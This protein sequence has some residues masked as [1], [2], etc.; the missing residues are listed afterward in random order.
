MGSP[1]RL[2]TSL[3]NSEKD[4]VL[5]RRYR[6]VGG[7]WQNSN[8]AGPSVADHCRDGGK[9]SKAGTTPYGVREELPCQP[10][11][12]P[13]PPPQTEQ[14]PGS[15]ALTPLK[16]KPVGDRQ[17]ADD[18]RSSVSTAATTE[19]S[20]GT[21]AIVIPWQPRRAQPLKAE[22]GMVRRFDDAV[23]ANEAG[24]GR[25]A[26]EKK[27]KKKRRGKP[28]PKE[29]N[30]G[31]DSDWEWNDAQVGHTDGGM[32]D[33]AE[34]TCPVRGC[35]ETILTLNLDSH[36]LARH[37]GSS[38]AADIR[39][40][41]ENERAFRERKE[42]PAEERPRIAG[43]RCPT[44]LVGILLA[45]GS[46]S[47]VSANYRPHPE[48]EKALA[49][50]G[51]EQR[52]Q[53]QQ[54]W[55]LARICARLVCSCRIERIGKMRERSLVELLGRVHQSV[56]S[57]L[58]KSKRNGKLGPIKEAMCKTYRQRTLSVDLRATVL[59]LW[60]YSEKLT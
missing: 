17:Y 51:P 1:D 30:N 36:I 44:P 6:V 54:D 35:H 39:R 41:Y 38:H 46:T 20:C 14:W 15:S 45:H 10:P 19:S 12:L 50:V 23:V 57:N 9:A 18:V 21:R 27:R 48:I 25:A 47:L 55:T 3:K 28:K 24:G 7:E 13:L 59:L 40:R 26:P 32:P 37:Q 5:G 22:G 58:P 29:G 11:P 52:Q 49:E 60:R 53:A 16:V 8:D 43:V 56:T 33:E 42:K 31:I 4:K 34:R 2:K